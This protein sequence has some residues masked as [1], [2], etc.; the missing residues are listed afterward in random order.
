MKIISIDERPIDE[1]F[2]QSAGARG[3]PETSTLPILRARA[4]RLPEGVTAVLVT[5]DLQGVAPSW[6][7][8]GEALLLGEVLAERLYDI[9]LPELASLGVVL[10]GDLFS[11]P[12]AAKRGAT[13]DVTSVWEAF[14]KISN[15]VVGVQGNHDEYSS[16]FPRLLEQNCFHLD[17]T[18]TT[19]GGITFGG[20]ALIAGNPDKRGRRSMEEQSR[21]IRDVSARC[22]DILLLHEGPPGAP[23]LQRGSDHI[24]EALHPDFSGLV[25][26]GHCHW[27]TPLA[28]IGR[29]QCMNVDATAIIVTL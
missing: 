7:A 10:C 16:R 18:L 17:G 12:D 4:D 26:A 20:V 15:W 11:A 13:G 27:S 23:H 24:L 25:L 19:I 6:S 29:V 8:G 14:S 9:D 2:F 22:P 28:S 5:S 3:K 1:L 21:L